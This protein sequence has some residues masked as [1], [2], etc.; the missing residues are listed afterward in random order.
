LPKILQ[1]TAYGGGE[2]RKLKEL[3]KMKRIYISKIIR[4]MLNL[5]IK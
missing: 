3:P 1:A 5:I 4:G 2:K